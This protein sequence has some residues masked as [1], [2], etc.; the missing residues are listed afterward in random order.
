VPGDVDLLKQNWQR[1]LLFMTPEGAEMLKQF[2]RE[3]RPDQMA[4]DW[5]VRVQIREVQPVTTSSYLVEWEE[6]FYKLPDMQLRQAKRYASVLSF[7]LEPPTQE[8]AEARLNWLGVK[9]YDAHWY[10]QPDVSRAAPRPVSAQKG[11]LP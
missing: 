11:E 7:R 4:K 3:V 9:V 8:T 6:R 10:A 5:R 1:A 2:G